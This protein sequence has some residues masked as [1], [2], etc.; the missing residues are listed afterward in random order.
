MQSSSARETP[1]D[2]GSSSPAKAADLRKE[3]EPQQ[4][5]KKLVLRKVNKGVGEMSA[6]ER[7]EMHVACGYNGAGQTPSLTTVRR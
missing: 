6:G 4:Q 3:D 2:A 7:L 5:K 1:S